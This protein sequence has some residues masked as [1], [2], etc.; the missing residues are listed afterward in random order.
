MAAA[1][2]RKAG[3]V[4]RGRFLDGSVGFRHLAIFLGGQREVSGFFD[5]VFTKAGTSLVFLYPFYLAD[6]VDRIV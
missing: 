5:R 1:H 6:I 3:A 4:D 2:R